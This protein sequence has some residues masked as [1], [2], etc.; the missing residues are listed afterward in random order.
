[1]EDPVELYKYLSIYNLNA[2]IILNVYCCILLYPF[3]DF[4][5]Y[6]VHNGTRICCSIYQE[7]STK[8]CGL[9]GKQTMVPAK[10]TICHTFI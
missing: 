1:M 5:Q 4:N 10:F 9:L 2:Y 3:F 6:A 8:C 7:S